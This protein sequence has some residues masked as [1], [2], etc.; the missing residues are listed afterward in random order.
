MDNLK[1]I[2]PINV[3]LFLL[4][5]ILLWVRSMNSPVLRAILQEDGPFENTQAVLYF[6]AGLGFLLIYIKNSRNWWYLPLS[7][8]L[9]WLAGEEISWGQRIFSIMSPAWEM[10]NNVQGELNLHNI[11]GIHQHIRLAGVLFCIFYF[12]VI[13][14]LSKYIAAIRGFISKL[15]LPV[16]PIWGEVAMIIGISVMVYDRG[17]LHR[18]DTQMTEIAETFISIGMFFFFLSE[19]WLTSNDKS[20]KLGA[21]INIVSPICFFLGI[22]FGLLHTVWPS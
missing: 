3:M 18:T 1:K 21:Y 12:V 7:L 8:L 19:Y 16:Y 22:L 14:F 15:R 13:P 2:N 11:N 6:L 20:K 10:K 4:A 17:I 5:C 9:I